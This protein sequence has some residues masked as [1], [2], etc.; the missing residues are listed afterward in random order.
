MGISPCAA[1]SR[2]IPYPLPILLGPYRRLDARQVRNFAARSHASGFSPPSVQRRLSAVRTF[3][4]I[5]IREGVLN[6]NTAKDISGPRMARRLPQTLTADEMARFI[7]GPK[8]VDQHFI[9]DRAIIELFYSSGLRLA[10]LV[11]LI[12]SNL[13]LSDRTVH[14]LG[15]GSRE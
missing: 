7:D 9:R 10:E 15:K 11:G 1:H 12:V 4:K 3:Q 13:D 6:Y 14:V 2:R 8:E 5:L